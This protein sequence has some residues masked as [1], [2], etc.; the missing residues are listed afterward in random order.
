MSSLCPVKHS[1]QIALA[2]LHSRV[3]DIM[4]SVWATLGCDTTEG[5]DDKEKRGIRSMSV[6]DVMRLNI[7]G[8]GSSYQRAEKKIQRQEM[9][10]NSRT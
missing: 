5:N 3:H 6:I 10:K 8:N 4:T 7:K 2:L 1:V 9:N